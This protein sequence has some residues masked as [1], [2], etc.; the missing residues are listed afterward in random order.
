M[1]IRKLL[2]RNYKS[3]EN[4]II[5]L[6]EDINLMKSDISVTCVGDNKQAT[7]KTNNST[8]NDRNEYMDVF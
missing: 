1:T 5:D 7:F 3:I 6:N 8:K 2:I 4:T